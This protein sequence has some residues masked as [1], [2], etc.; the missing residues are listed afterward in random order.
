VNASA[1]PPR[2]AS[3]SVR[4]TPS[5]GVSYVHVAHVDHG[6]VRKLLAGGSPRSRRSTGPRPLHSLDDLASTI[7]HGRPGDGGTDGRPGAQPAA[8]SQRDDTGLAWLPGLGTGQDTS[9]S[10][11]ALGTPTGTWDAY[12]GAPTRAPNAATVRPAP[13]A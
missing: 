1:G 9:G 11:S 10:G 5:S 3:R 12:R 4:P 7:M 8:H 2:G 6:S 13:L